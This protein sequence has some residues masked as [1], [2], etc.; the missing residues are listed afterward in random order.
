M[1]AEFS[2]FVQCLY[3]TDMVPWKINQA[4]AYFMK[5]Q[6]DLNSY[7]ICLS[8]LNDMQATEAGKGLALQTMKKLMERYWDQY[9]AKD[10]MEMRNVSE[11]LFI[12]RFCILCILAICAICDESKGSDCFFVPYDLRCVCCLDC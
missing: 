8:I 6:N 3:G 2:Y 12:T 9:T 7:A 10:Q 1:A 4:N 11:C 5:F